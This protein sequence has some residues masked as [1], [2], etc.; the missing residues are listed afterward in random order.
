VALAAITAVAFVIRLTQ[1]RQGL[2]GDE[3]TTYSEVV[4]RSLSSVMTSVNTGG[5]NSPPLFFV[6]AWLCAK[7]GDPTVWIRVPSLVLGTAT[8]PLLFLLGR[9]VAG[10]SVGLIAAAV[11]ALSPF[12]TY[13][14]IE[15]RPYATMAFFLTLA[16][17]ALIKAVRSGSWWWWTAFALAALGAA[18]SHYTSIFVLLAAFAWALWSC[19][20]R[21]LKPVAAGCAVVL[22][23]VPWLSHIQG[24]LL[25]VINF[26]HPLTVHNVLTDLARPIA[27]HPDAPLSTIPTVPG[28]VILAAAAIAGLFILS[29]RR[30]EAPFDMGNTSERVLIVIL[31]IA[32]P[33]G[34]L[35][36]SVLKSD[37]WLPRSLYSSAPSQALLFAI[38]LVALP[39]RAMALIAG[40]VFVV[41][42]IGTARTYSANVARP[43]YRE[44]AAH[45]DAVAG[46]AQPIVTYPSLVGE[47]VRPY[48]RRRH[49]LLSAAPGLWRSLRSNTVYVLI[50]DA[51]AYGLYKSVPRPAGFRLVGHRH[52][53]GIKPTDLYTYER[54]R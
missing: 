52:Y 31:A 33:V 17:L 30:G 49:L 40:A 16:T 9:E 7:L 44:I 21:L 42:A 5:E 24:T 20:D 18:Y 3:L 4:G 10:R 28:L 1:M 54:T 6:L 14:G 39:R 29:V 2:L 47:G 45:L 25:F 32:A 19:R 43:P 48:Y 22:F 36:Y 12:S 11:L 38:V 35:L 27:G 34:V 51:G 8:I 23:Y 50:Y 26:L 13:Y 37:V 46:P 53:V 15:A 41:L